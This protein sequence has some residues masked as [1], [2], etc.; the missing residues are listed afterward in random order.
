[1]KNIFHSIMNWGMLILCFIS[2][3]LYIIIE[4]INNMQV[5]ADFPISLFNLLNYLIMKKSEV[6]HRM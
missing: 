6:D 2:S 3:N 4:L 5:V 1:M